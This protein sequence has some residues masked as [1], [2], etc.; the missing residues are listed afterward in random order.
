MRNIDTIIVHCSYTP[1]SMNIGVAEIRDWH[2]NERK[3]T[4]I[5]YHYVIRRD[6]ACE[7]GRPIEQVGAHAKPGNGGSVGVCLVGGMAEGDQRPDCNFTN[8]Q[9]V[10]LQNLVQELRELYDIKIDRVIGHR[11]VDPGKACPTFDV[12]AW[13]SSLPILGES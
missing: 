7:P 13:A 10:A 5:G 4:D 1:P 2:V 8:I 3:F 12:G 11:D 6:G 9:W